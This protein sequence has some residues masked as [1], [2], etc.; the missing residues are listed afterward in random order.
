MEAK[1]HSQYND[2]I[3]IIHKETD[4]AYYVTQ[5]K[6]N[7]VNPV[8]FWIEKSNMKQFEKIKYNLK[9]KQEGKKKKQT[10]HQRIRALH[11]K[12]NLKQKQCVC[13]SKYNLQLHHIT[14]TE[15]PNVVTLCERC[16]AKVHQ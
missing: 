11:K 6:N 2:C 7:W 4:K 15:E 1:I 3:L 12:M 10:E 16:H 5:I 8:R 14:Y 9:T 13:G